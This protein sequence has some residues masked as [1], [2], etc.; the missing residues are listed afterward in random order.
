MVH[1][2][3]NKEHYCVIIARDDLEDK[4]LYDRCSI[5]MKNGYPCSS[6][7]TLGP[8]PEND[9]VRHGEISK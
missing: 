5:H 3:N 1:N 8:I 7:M 2:V 9:D 6:M 4:M